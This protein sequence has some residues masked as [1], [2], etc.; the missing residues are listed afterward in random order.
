MAT[1]C[2][3]HNSR[4]R[5]ESRALIDSFAGSAPRESN[6]IQESAGTWWHL[7]QTL[8]GQAVKPHE[9]TALKC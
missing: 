6:F 5:L 3:S 8:Q 7:G 4:G 1:R 9:A 2:R